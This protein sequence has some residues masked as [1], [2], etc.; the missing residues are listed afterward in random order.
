MYKLSHL[1]LCFIPCS[2]SFETDDLV[3]GILECKKGVIV[4]SATELSHVFHLIYLYL[5][6]W[7]NYFN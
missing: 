6:M 2:T 3:V 7:V 4:L 5:Y 1:V